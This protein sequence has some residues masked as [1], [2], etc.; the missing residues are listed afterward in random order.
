MINCEKIWI[1]GTSGMVGGSVTKYL[2]DKNY[3]V[4][5]LSNSGKN[6]NDIFNINYQDKN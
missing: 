4:V 2:M 5:K 1:T 3:Q 6:Y